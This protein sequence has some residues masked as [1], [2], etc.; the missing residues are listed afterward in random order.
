MYKN[1]KA[2]NGK[3]RKIPIIHG[4]TT[5][6]GVSFFQPYSGAHGAKDM[7]KHKDDGKNNNVPIPDEAG[8]R[9]YFA[10]AFESDGI[11]VAES[12]KSGWRWPSVGKEFEDM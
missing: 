5:D 3:P 10:W 4:T 6:E 11:G 2:G 12:E 1:K 8:F 7:H 9:K